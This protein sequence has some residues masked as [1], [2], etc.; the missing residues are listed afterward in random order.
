MHSK[1]YKRR[2]QSKG[3]AALEFLT[4]YSW[5]F[6]ALIIILGGLVYFDIFNPEHYIPESCNFGTNI[7]CEDVS[8]QQKSANTFEL[9]IK[10]KNNLEKGIEPVN[11]TIYSNDF[12]KVQNC[13]FYFHCPSDSNNAN[14]TAGSNGI[15][16]AS[17]SIWR[18]GASC[19]LQAT[20]CEKTI[21]QND[22]ETLNLDFSFKRKGG[23]TPHKVW[24][25]AFVEVS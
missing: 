19:R 25:R 21:V 20:D 6:M 15:F 9:N 10:L 8:L 7:M 11:V 1:R 22:K 24:A 16:G 5:A 13:N 23:S 12:T 4:T 3:Q 17:N 18:V 14:W 2:R